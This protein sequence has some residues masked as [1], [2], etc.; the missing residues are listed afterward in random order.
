MRFSPSAAEQARLNEYSSEERFQYAITRM[1]ECEEVWS[2]G[3]DDGWLI[4]DVDG[5]SAIAI[6]PYRQMAVAFISG[7]ASNSEPVSVSLEHF[8]YTLLKQCEEA[9]IVLDV[10][11]SPLE[12]GYVIGAAQLYEILENMVETG[13]YFIEG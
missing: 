6:W 13:S 9:R 1:C 3:D 2:L 10:N 12:K 4:R 5:Q 7:D 11:P 8:L